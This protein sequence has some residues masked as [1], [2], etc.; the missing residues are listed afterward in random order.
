MKQAR[1][2]MNESTAVTPRKVGQSGCTDGSAP[3][4]FR[5][6]FIIKPTPIKYERKRN[7]N[8]NQRDSQAIPST[9]FGLPSMRCSENDLGEHRNYCHY[10]RTTQLTPSGR[11]NPSQIRL[12]QVYKARCS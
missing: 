9:T 11:L 5:K 8:N 7:F 2:A 6:L 4:T 1:R 3:R 10:P 12:H